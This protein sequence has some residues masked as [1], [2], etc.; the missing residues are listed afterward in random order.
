MANFA[1]QT[2]DDEKLLSE[3]LRRAQLNT[4]KVIVVTHDI[5]ADLASSSAQLAQYSVAASLNEVRGCVGSWGGGI[6]LGG[7]ACAWARIGAVLATKRGWG[8]FHR[9]GVG[10]GAEGLAHSP[11]HSLG[12]QPAHSEVQ[13]HSMTGPSAFAA[14]AAAAAACVIPAAV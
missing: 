8:S 2:R 4:V 1:C 11:R 14:A 12:C 7:G 5:S 10:V 6:Y 13:H 3:E 9:G